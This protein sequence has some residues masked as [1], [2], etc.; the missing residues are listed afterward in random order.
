M[1]SIT[2]KFKKYKLQPSHER[3]EDICKPAKFTLQPQQLF[4]R[5]FFNDKMSEKGLLVYH[6]I[7]AG[8]TCTAITMAE[9]LKEK[10]NIMVLLPA[11]LIGNFKDELRG[12]CGK[13]MTNEE[14]E[15]IK[16]LSP[17]E[18]LYKNILDKTDERIEKYYTIYS[19]HKFV[20]LAEKNKI[21]LVNTLL[22][23][24][25]VQNMVSEGG[26][27]YKNLK[28]VIDKSDNKTR[29]LLLSATPMFDKPDE[30]ALTLN[31]L[32]IKKE[33]PIGREFNTMF[34]KPFKTD[35]GT[36]YDMINKDKLGGY[37]KNIIS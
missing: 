18:K 14:R 26:P 11:A 2:E 6:K 1:S 20:E 25:E 22:I 32:K 27:F 9:S 36:D 37:M 13:Y 23:V 7:G 29:I 10:M 3:M 5:D 28:K 31:L 19:Y 30:I 17:K 16:T 8:K 34:L 12:E 4:L 21:K 33:I 35:I 15:V 24:D